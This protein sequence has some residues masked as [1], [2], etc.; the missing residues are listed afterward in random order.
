MA[1]DRPDLCVTNARLAEQRDLRIVSWRR[2]LKKS[3]S[4]LP[5]RQSKGGNDKCRRRHGRC[6]CRG[7]ERRAQSQRAPPGEQWPPDELENPQYQETKEKRGEGIHAPDQKF[8]TNCMGGSEEIYAAREIE[9]V[10]G[11][12]E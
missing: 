9:H 11:S 2:G 12:E 10:D 4:Q 8:G 5:V 1:R 7:L 3:L 6:R